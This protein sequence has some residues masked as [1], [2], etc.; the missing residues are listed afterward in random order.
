M[1]LKLATLVSALSSALIVGT[2]HA[3]EVSTSS[4]NTALAA[5]K[6]DVS[7]VANTTIVLV[8]SFVGLLIAAG[9]GWRFIK[10]H[11]GKKI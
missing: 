8:L 10:R 9:F 7:E 1:K 5:V 2:A 4:I 11:I 3:A 6:A